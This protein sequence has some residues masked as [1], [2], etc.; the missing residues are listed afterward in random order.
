MHMSSM[1][2]EELFSREQHA[3]VVLCCAVMGACF[4][5]QS[6]NPQQ[7]GGYQQGNL[8]GQQQGQT[9]YAGQS[10]GY[11]QQQPNNW[12]ASEGYPGGTN[13]ALAS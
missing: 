2:T 8:Y 3:Y 1:H 7:P 13:H 9:G 10:G 4:G 11:Q 12:N 6:H 5:K